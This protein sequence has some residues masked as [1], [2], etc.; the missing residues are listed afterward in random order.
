SIT[1]RHGVLLR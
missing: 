1:Q